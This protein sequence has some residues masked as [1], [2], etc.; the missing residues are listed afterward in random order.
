MRVLA[1]PI[2]TIESM[3]IALRPIRS[4]RLP[5]TRPPMGRTMN[6]NAK[7][8][9]AAIEPSTGSSVGKKTTLK[10]MAVRLA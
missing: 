9:K 2:T 4:A 5:K 10:T 8:A 1:T 7:V 3:R 6:P